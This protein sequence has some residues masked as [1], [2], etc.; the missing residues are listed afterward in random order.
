MWLS[1]VALVGLLFGLVTGACSSGEGSGAQGSTC[2]TSASGPAIQIERLL[3]AVADA[4]C[5][6]IARCCPGYDSA[7]CK[8]E[9]KAG[10][11]PIVE[12]VRSGVV[13]YDAAA[14][15]N[16]VAALKSCLSSCSFDVLSSDVASC[17]QAVQGTV[18]EG[19]PC[20]SSAECYEPSGTDAT[21]DRS[22]G[23]TTGVCTVKVPPPKG[24]LGTPCGRTCEKEGAATWCYGSSGSPGTADC[25]RNE[26]LYCDDESGTC[27]ALI[28]VGTTGCGYD[29]KACQTGYCQSDTCHP[30]KTAGSECSYG[31]CDSTTYCNT[32]ERV[33]AP[34]KP[35]GSAC[36]S[37]T[38]CASDRCDYDS[39]TCRP[40]GATGQ[41][42]CDFWD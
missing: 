10:A 25:Y 13:K 26:G 7:G 36:E 18:R 28:P 30:F 11:Q 5:D 16:C 32:A 2:G 12:Q 42:F 14:A 21:C 6:S 1:R 40:T 22:G 24:T 39:K 35:D 15:G 38:E 4:F 19:G 27:A 41:N 29:A 23:S 17:E 37:S 31:Q 8:A 33:C 9:Y 3:D 20:S 34:R